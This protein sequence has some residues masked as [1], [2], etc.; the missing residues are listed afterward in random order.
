M[1]TLKYKEEVEEELFTAKD[2]EIGEMMELT[3]HQTFK[4]NIILK[5]YDTFVNLMSPD[6]VWSHSVASS[7]IGRKLLPG[8]GITL[9]QE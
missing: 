2:L 5:T 8:E 3:A 7:L 6:D 1:K 9:I 4:G